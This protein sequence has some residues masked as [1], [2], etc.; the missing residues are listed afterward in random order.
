VFS[1]KSHRIQAEASQ[2]IVWRWHPE[3]ENEGFNEGNALGDQDRLDECLVKPVSFRLNLLFLV[4][5]G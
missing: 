4:I 1:V 2:Q 5:T 3:G